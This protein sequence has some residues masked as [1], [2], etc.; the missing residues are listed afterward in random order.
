MTTIMTAGT[1]GIDLRL[2][3]PDDDEIPVAFDD[4]P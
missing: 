4:W 3:E 1:D 2:A